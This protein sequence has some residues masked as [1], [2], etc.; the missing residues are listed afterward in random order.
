MIFSLAFIGYL[1]YNKSEGKLISEITSTDMTE[2]EKITQFIGDCKDKLTESEA[3]Y[4]VCCVDK[5]KLYNCTDKKE[6]KPEEFVIV[7]VDLHKMN[8]FFD[9]Y[10]AYGFYF[11]KEVEGIPE[12]KENV[13][14]VG[15]T[16]ISSLIFTE[17]LNK[18]RYNI[19]SFAGNIQHNK[20]YTLLME[21]RIYPDGNYATIDDFMANIDKSK[22]GACVSE[23]PDSTP[24]SPG[25]FCCQSESGGGQY[26]CYITG[27]CCEMGTENEYWYY[28]CPCPE[29]T[30]TTSSSTSSTS[31]ILPPYNF[32]IWV[33]GPNLLK[34]GEKVPVLL[35]IQNLGKN[36]DN[37]NIDYSIDSDYP[38]LIDVDMGD[39]S[40]MQD[41]PSKEIR[42]KTVRVML[43]ESHVSADIT[44]T[45]TSENTG[46]Q[47]STILSVL[48]GDFEMNLSE[49]SFMGIIVLRLCHNSFFLK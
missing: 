40:S 31:T 47:G 15:Y 19:L 29:T 43:L 39:A 16:D 37:Y 38:H 28:E 32:R 45:G 4:I 2:Q 17:K 35:Y 30:T 8:T 3:Y 46:E 20:G 42:V 9:P 33:E 6:F 1:F 24:P 36:N 5:D 41:L 21:I 44:F 26:R 14:L 34:V 12:Y 48:E 49:F 23:I 10:Y 25:R 7:H 13:N 18:N 22:N 27:C 11:I